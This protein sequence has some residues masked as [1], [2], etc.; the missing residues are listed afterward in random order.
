MSEMKEAPIPDDFDPNVSSPQSQPQPSVIAND[1]TG[2]IAIIL[3][4]TGLVTGL[5][6]LG[7]VAVIFGHKALKRQHL[8]KNNYTFGMVGLITGYVQ[9]GLLALV[10]L[11][12]AIIPLIFF[13]LQ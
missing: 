7:I 8:H 10:I 4:I 1:N 11:L 9:I 6:V 3:G 5:L 12:F 13:G 2:L